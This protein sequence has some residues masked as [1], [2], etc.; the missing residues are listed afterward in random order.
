MTEEI[1]SPEHKKTSEKNIWRKMIKRCYDVSDPAFKNYGARGIE[2]CVQWKNCFDNFFKDM[3]P[4]PSKNHSLDRINNGGNYS[5]DNCRWATWREQNNNRR[6]NIRLTFK[7]KTLTISQW[8]DEINVN[9]GTLYD[10]W[11]NGYS[12]EE[13]L[14][15]G[16]HPFNRRFI[17]FNGTRKTLSEWAAVLD[18]GLSA[19]HR[20]LKYWPVERAL[21]LPRRN[22]LKALENKESTE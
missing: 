11:A 7:N 15:D 19:L 8:A 16:I 14:N 3:G 5:P 10:R 2:V 9:V 20:R 21:T 18:L 22:R 12:V 17:D 4:R 13:T 6:D 1:K